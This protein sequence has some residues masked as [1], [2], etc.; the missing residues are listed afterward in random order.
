MDDY[1]GISHSLCQY[2]ANEA[3]HALVIDYTNN[4]LTTDNISEPSEKL[5]CDISQ[6][7]CR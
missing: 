1:L 4:Y 2:Y 7:L 6:E 3:S 5:I